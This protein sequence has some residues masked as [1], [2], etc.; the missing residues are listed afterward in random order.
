[1]EE[2]GWGSWEG[3]GARKR[4]GLSAAGR[5]GQGREAERGGGKSAVPPR[6]LFFNANRELF[7]F[8]LNSRC[9]Y[10]LSTSSLFLQS[11]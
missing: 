3:R 6:L 10:K 7:A 2:E 4:E 1:M 8:H 9:C 5:K 11:L